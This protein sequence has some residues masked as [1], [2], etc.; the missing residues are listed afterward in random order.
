MWL[1]EFN[2]QSNEGDFSIVAE[3]VQHLVSYSDRVRTISYQED[4]EV[5]MRIA[6]QCRAAIMMRYQACLFAY[7]VGVSS[8]WINYHR[9]ISFLAEDVLLPSYELVGLETVTGAYLAARIGE[10]I[11]HIEDFLP[12][13]PVKELA[14]RLEKAVVQL[15]EEM[16]RVLGK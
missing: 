12:H 7:L 15:M 13:R 6:A 11:Q 10:L 3:V 14:Q 1:L 4:P 9:K 2:W 16:A 8:I 5:M